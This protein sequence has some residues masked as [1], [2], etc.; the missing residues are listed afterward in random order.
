VIR[1][2]RRPR[3]PAALA[4]KADEK[5]DQ[6]AA[7]VAA[8][9]AGVAAGDLK[10]PFDAKTYGGAPV[11]QALIRWQHGKCAFCE[12]KI[13]AN[14]YGD[15]E[16]FRPKGAVADPATGQLT[17][18]GY[19][20]LAYDWSNLFYGCQ[21]CNQAFK[22]NHFPLVDP[23]ARA[24]GPEDDL[25]AEAPL[26]LN[27]EHDEPAEHLGFEAE[28]IFPKTA[29]GEATVRLLGLD[30]EAMD[31]ARRSVWQIL[32]ALYQIWLR[33]PEGPDREI[34]AAG[35]RAATGDHAPF[36]AMSRALVGRI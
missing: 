10:L 33:L 24:R 32:S 12:A 6:L 20:W 22:K 14:Q 13:D 25:A 21:L 31:E 2:A 11:K 3:P 1:L 15:V 29:R 35:L 4:N 26:L 27:P 28:L 8:G 23:A 19:W 18:P 7:I 9:L 36:L 17:W 5:R 34:A 16:H 30:R